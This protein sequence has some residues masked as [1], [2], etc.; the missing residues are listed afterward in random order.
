MCR[1]APF[2]ARRSVHDGGAGT[3][4]ERGE[5]PG[6]VAQPTGASAHRLLVARSL[7]ALPRT[8]GIDSSFARGGARGRANVAATPRLTLGMIC[9]CAIRTEVTLGLDA[10]VM[11]DSA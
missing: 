6:L 7:V 5:A 8:G 3:I 4:G 11:D 2:V 9:Q 10:M 1:S